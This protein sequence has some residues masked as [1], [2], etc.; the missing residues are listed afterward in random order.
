MDILEFVAPTRASLDPI[1]HELI[2]LIGSHRLL[3]FYGTMGAGKTTFIQ[4]I[5]R[6]LGVA[7]EVTS[8]TFAIVNEYQADGE[9]LVYHFDFYRIKDITEVLDFGIDEYFD[10]GSWCLMEWPEKLEMLLPEPLVRI[11]LEEQPDAARRI[12][13]E[14]PY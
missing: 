2:S 6:A 4:A 13:V 10:S 5:C 1:A 3:A 12:R 11:F 14:L 7:S 9:A 8:P